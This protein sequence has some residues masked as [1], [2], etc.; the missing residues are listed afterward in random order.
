[1][2]LWN[3][4]K[5]AGLQWSKVFRLCQ[6]RTPISFQG[7]TIRPPGTF[8]SDFL[9]NRHGRALWENTRIIYT[10]EFAALI[11]SGMDGRANGL[12]VGFLKAI[13]DGATS[14]SSKK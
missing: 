3:F 9:S 11:D 13:G 4:V 12:G 10:P 2:W 5:T 1:L 7:W 14:D 8:W 6:E